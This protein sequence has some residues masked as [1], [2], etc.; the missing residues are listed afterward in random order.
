[1]PPS[2]LANP[3]TSIVVY[4]DSLSDNGNIY[5][6][7]GNTYPASPPYYNGRLSNG[8]V[9]VEQMATTWGVPLYDFAYG[10]ATTGIGNASDGGAP[11]SLGSLGLPGMQSELASTQGLLGSLV[12]FN[13]SLFVVWGGPND[14]FSAL[15]QNTLSPQTVDRAVS[16]LTGI[17]TTLELLGAKNILVPGMPDLGLTP[18]VRAFG[19]VAATQA[20]LATQAFN[21][22]LIADLP[23]G[24]I[25]YDT[26]SL[27]SSMYNNP[28]AFGFT[29]VTDPC[30]DGTTVCA[31]PDQ[32]L[33]WDDVH[34]TT[35]ADAVLA[36]AFEAAAVPEPTPIV[37]LTA[38]L[39]LCLVVRRRL[40]PLR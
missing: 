26:A 19:T 18:K 21:A 35:A 4:G 7:S 25:Y 11:T 36:G 1:M 24:A 3:F 32:Y 16:D 31:N 12:D 37:F 13:T 40:L 38:A 28:A 29:D 22:E 33:I 14:F 17:V 23:A 5:A 2:L 20:S 15:A 9:T 34:P 30:F 10:G 6:A 27:L 8:P 39:S